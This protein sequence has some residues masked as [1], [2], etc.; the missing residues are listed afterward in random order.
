MA[1]HRIWGGLMLRFSRVFARWPVVAAIALLSSASI[2]AAAGPVSAQTPTDWT[3]YLYS[4]GH[5]SYNAADTA[6][7]PANAGHLTKVWQWKGDAATMSGQP[8]PALFASPTVADGAVF[9][10]AN[11]GY[12]YKLNET[13]GAVLAK[14]FIGYQPKLTCAARGFIST[15]TVTTDPSDGQETVYV[16]APDG[17]LYAFNASD[18]SVKWRSVIDIPSTTVN[19]YFNWSSP[20]VAN[21]KIYVGSASHCDKPAHPRLGNRLRPGHRVTSSPGSSRCP[22]ATSAAA[23]GRAWPW[24]ALAM[25]TPP[26][27]RQPKNTTNRYYSVSIVKLDPNTLQPLGSFTVPNSQL[28][29]D[30]DFG[31]SP[32]I[33]GPDVGALQQERDLLRAGPLHHA[34]GL[35]NPD[36]CQVV[37]GQPGAMLGGGDLRRHVPVHGG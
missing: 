29:G 2:L 25:C 34:G 26:P 12:F 37:L 35:G 24:T 20:T 23:S 7:T 32:T 16:A 6:I 8:G 19:D 9:I 10:G 5:S 30:G 1:W 36:R 13:T 4:A 31:G 33:F 11:N 18:L 15:A 17:Y 27:A 3:G 21:G 28:G 14:V 22:T